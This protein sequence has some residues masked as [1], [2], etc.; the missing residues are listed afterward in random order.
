MCCAKSCVCKCK[1]PDAYILDVQQ[2]HS[3]SEWFGQLGQVSRASSTAVLT[4]RASQR[5]L[6]CPQ[7]ALTRSPS[8]ATRPCFRASAENARNFSFATSAAIETI[9]LSRAAVTSMFTG[10]QNRDKHV[11]RL[12]QQAQHTTVFLAPRTAAQ[13]VAQGP[14]T[15][16]AL[17]TAAPSPTLLHVPQVLDRSQTATGQAS[18]GVQAAQAASAELKG[19]FQCRI[20]NSVPV[21]ASDVEPVPVPPPAMCTTT[22]VKMPAPPKVLWQGRGSPNQ[23]GVV[24]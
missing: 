20:A 22:S 4:G 17:S 16:P 19:T 23:C 7:V 5:R 11:T 24:G 12:Q 14:A 13:I 1:M 6:T 9:F 18:T 21:L 8:V 2:L 3:A 10:L 15:Q